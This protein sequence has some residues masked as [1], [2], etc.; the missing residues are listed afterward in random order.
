MSSESPT[1]A[2][3]PTR[4]DA[5]AGFL[6][7]AQ[8]HFE[9]VA[10]ELAMSAGAEAH[11]AHMAPDQVAKTIVLHDGSAY[12]IAAISAA[13]RLDLHKLRELLGAT[14][15]LR[16]ASEAEIAR[17]FP[18][19]EVGAIPPFGPMVPAAEVLDS[20]LAAQ[21]RILCPAGDHRHSLLLDPRDVVRITAAT[22]ADI[23][24]E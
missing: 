16:L 12:V 1:S 20:A 7:G 15:Q 10:H 4:V 8:V 19:L 21:P 9:L 13:D 11:A 24:E 6:E 18:S 5:I 17:D 23:C 2:V 22:V 14:H 3:S